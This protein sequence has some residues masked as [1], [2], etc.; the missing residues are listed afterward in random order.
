MKKLFLLM[1]ITILFLSCAS[2]AYFIRSKS[3]D[4]SQYT[5]K[6]FF[7]TES[8]SVSFEYM[9]LGSI[10]VFG[11]N[12]YELSSL[13]DE[14][15]DPD[16]ALLLNNYTNKKWKTINI[17]DLIAH[18]YEEAIAMGADGVINLQQ[19]YLPAN[20]K[21]NVLEGWLVTGMAIKRVK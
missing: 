12:G 14:V 20:E 5:A 16:G 3:I 4:F 17:N 2:P 6:G 19:I 9:P 10:S 15:Q 18:L 7:F 13:K 21:Q 11:R 1:A 8:N